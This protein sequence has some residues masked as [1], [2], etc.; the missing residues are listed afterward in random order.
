MRLTWIAVSF[1]FVVEMGAQGAPVQPSAQ[2]PPPAPAAAVKTGTITVTGCLQSITGGSGAASSGSHY[3]LSTTAT[4]SGVS[5]SPAAPGAPAR[6][7]PDASGASRGT[8]EASGSSAA[9]TGYVLHG[10]ADE[11]GKHTGHRVEITGTVSEGTAPG[12][13]ATTGTGAAPS[14]PE[15]QIIP[16]EPHRGP[17]STGTGGSPSGSAAVQHLSVQSVRMLA[18]SCQ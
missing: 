16:H 7:G 3:R 17:V 5:G 14:Q 6:S 10:R 2:Q 13:V 12:A 15:T 8:A 18:A 11:L 4:T 1:A 9:P